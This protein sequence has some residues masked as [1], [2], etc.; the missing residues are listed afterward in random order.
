MVVLLVDLRAVLLV[1]PL[2]GLRA[3][4]LAGLRAVLLG[5]L[6]VGLRAG[7]LGAPQLALAMVLR[8]VLRKVL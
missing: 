8:E 2:G 4:L 3:G 5:A 1:V 6:L 7:L